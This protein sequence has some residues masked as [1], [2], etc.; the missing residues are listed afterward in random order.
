[1]RREA[2]KTFADRGRKNTPQKI[3]LLLRG[4]KMVNVAHK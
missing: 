3:Q 4:E 1:M 2:G